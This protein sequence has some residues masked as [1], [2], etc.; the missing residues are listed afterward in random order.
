MRSMEPVHPVEPLKPNMSQHEPV[1]PA[2]PVHP[3]KP[4]S[5]ADLTLCAEVE[6]LLPVYR[7]SR[8]IVFDKHSYRKQPAKMGIMGVKTG[9]G[10]PMHRARQCGD[11]CS[12]YLGIIYRLAIL[13][14]F[15]GFLEAYFSWASLARSKTPRN[16]RKY[17]F[18]E[19]RLAY[20]PITRKE[21]KSYIALAIALL[22]TGYAP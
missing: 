14:L 12:G 19:Y 21:R 10:S 15:L 5:S 22:Y 1:E 20:S 2:R 6:G 18:S 17:L 11:E 7:K 13:G 16:C 4:R 9:T 3:V 8:Q